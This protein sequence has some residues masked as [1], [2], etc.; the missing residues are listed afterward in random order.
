M[1][2]AMLG[3]ARRNSQA[4]WFSPLVQP[5]RFSVATVVSASARQPEAAARESWVKEFDVPHHT[6]EVLTAVPLK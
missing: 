1:I 4:S 2:R 3:F 5:A 6:L